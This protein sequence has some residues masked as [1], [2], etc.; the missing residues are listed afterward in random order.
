MGRVLAKRWCWASY[1]IRGSP[2]I[3]WVKPNQCGKFSRWMCQWKDTKFET[4]LHWYKFKITSFKS[5]YL[6]IFSIAIHLLSVIPS[7][8]VYNMEINVT[9]RQN[10]ITSKKKYT[11]THNYTYIKIFPFA[12]EQY[13]STNFR[14]KNVLKAF[15]CFFE[16]VMLLCCFSWS[17]RSTTNSK[18]VR[19]YFQS[20]TVSTCSDQ[21][22]R[23]NENAL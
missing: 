4:H 19:N 8:C 7:M 12:S 11:G 23:W 14:F 13:I 9:W 15:I 5:M 10:E 2:R 16:P 21:D 17:H 18:L 20:C 22:R 3:I 1:S 6:L